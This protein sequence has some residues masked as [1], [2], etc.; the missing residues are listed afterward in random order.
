MG[1]FWGQSFCVKIHFGLEE[2]LENLGGENELKKGLQRK[3]GPAQ[4]S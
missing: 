1:K 2:K 3:K 4:K